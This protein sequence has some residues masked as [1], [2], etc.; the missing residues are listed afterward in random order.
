[1]N[2]NDIVDIRS[3]V[4][5][6]EK[7][8]KMVEREVRTKFPELFSEFLVKTKPSKVMIMVIIVIILETFIMFSFLRG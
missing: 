5:S 1:M 3:R 8:K 4:P 2:P 6:L 7:K